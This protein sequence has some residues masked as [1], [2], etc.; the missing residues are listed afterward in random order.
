LPLET[1]SPHPMKDL[2]R[3]IFR[4]GNID[5]I[6]L[7]P[8]VIEAYWPEFNTEGDE[9]MEL[10][11]LN[12]ILYDQVLLEIRIAL[13]QSDSKDFIDPIQNRDLD[14]MEE[15]A[16]SGNVFNGTIDQNNKDL[17]LLSFLPM[18]NHDSISHL[19]ESLPGGRERFSMS[20]MAD[21]FL[22]EPDL[23][24]ISEFLVRRWLLLRP[25]LFQIDS[26]RESLKRYVRALADAELSSYEIC[27]IRPDRLLDFVQIAYQRGQ[28]FSYHARNVIISAYLQRIINRSPQCQFDLV[29][30]LRAVINRQWDIFAEEQ[31]RSQQEQQGAPSLQ[32]EA[33]QQRRDRSTR[34]NPL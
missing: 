5:Q 23:V 32:S 30:F 3:E 13:V 6:H 9:G 4:R 27:E 15:I 17:V 25:D 26:D 22:R 33:R 24:D 10:D 29:A 8:E 34:Y 18:A 14:A 19:L 16:S 12:Q 21:L 2:I 1:N 20:V 11:R 28:S 7:I 31:R